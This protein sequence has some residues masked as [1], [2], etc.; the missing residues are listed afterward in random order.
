[1]F[2]SAIV[3]TRPHDIGLQDVELTPMK[4]NDIAVDVSWSGI[5]TGT[6]KLFFDGTMPPF[7]GMGYPLVPGYESVGRVVS[8]GADSGFSQDETVFVPGANCYNGARGLFGATAARV[9]L[10]GS[11]AIRVSES[12]GEDAV[13][14]SLAATAYHA[15]TLRDATP[16][17]LIVGFGVLGRLIARIAIALGHPAPRV[18]ERNPARRDTAEAV[19]VVD[20]ADD[21][22][23][24]YSTIMDVSGDPTILDTLVARL[25]KGGTITLAGFYAAPLSFSFPPAF[26]RE[27]RLFIA[28]EFTPADLTAVMGLVDSGR[29]SL[30]G[31]ISHRADAGDAPKA[32]ATAFGDPHCTKMI[33]DWR[34]NG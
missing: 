13:L 16:P 21:A 34:R 12:L 6:E 9:V 32:Y 26:M 22:R 24:D 25:S 28:A 33:L 17:E 15:L 30:G 27:A 23:T 1:M 5:S 14:L 19:E 8:A 3:L 11:R 31:L 29:L 7:P 20:G 4:E 10:P 18:W 2:T